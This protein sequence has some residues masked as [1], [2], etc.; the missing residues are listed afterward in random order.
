MSER[1]QRRTY[2]YRGPR[3][4]EST[5]VR[6]VPATDEELARRAGD[7]VSILLGARAVERERA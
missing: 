3:R 7:V 4:I 6:A 1:G 5:T 2:R